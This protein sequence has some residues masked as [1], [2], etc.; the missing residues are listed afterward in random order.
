MYLQILLEVDSSQILCSV[1]TAILKTQR[2]THKQLCCWLLLHSKKQED[3][4]KYPKT[5]YKKIE[6]KGGNLTEKIK[7]SPDERQ[8]KRAHENLTKTF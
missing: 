6:K 5:F 8:K 4:V 2:A 7:R 1:L 3:P